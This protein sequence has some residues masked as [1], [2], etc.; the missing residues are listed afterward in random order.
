MRGGAVA[1]RVSDAEVFTRL[2]FFGTV[3]MGMSDEKFWFMPVGQFLDLWACYKQ[4]H[5]LEKPI[6]DDTEQLDALFP[7]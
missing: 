7:D 3:L 1:W 5:G 2:Y 4:I 6:Y